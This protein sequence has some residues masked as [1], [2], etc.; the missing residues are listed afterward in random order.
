NGPQFNDAVVKW[1]LEHYLGLVETDPEPVLLGDAA[2]E[3]YCG[4]YATVAVDCYISADAGRLSIKVEPNAET[5]KALTE[6]GATEDD[7]KQPPIVIGMLP[8]DGD[9][10][11]VA[12][13]PAKGMKGYFKRDANGAITG[14]HIGG[15]MATR[16]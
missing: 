2:L 13:G 9:R 3:E 11:I 10:Y 5:I 4:H 14:A 12:E 6:D 15:R 16:V 7:L 8:G 1:A